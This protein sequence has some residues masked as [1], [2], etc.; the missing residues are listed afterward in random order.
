MADKKDENPP[1]PTVEK[2]PAATEEAA[3]STEDA[4]GQATPPAEPQS[5]GQWFNFGTEWMA[6]AKEQ[7]LNTLESVK[8]SVKKD[9][10]EFQETVSKEAT[11]LASASQ[12]AVKQQAE[13]LQQFVSTP[14]TAESEKPKEK[15]GEASGFGL[16]WMKGL[17]ETVKSLSMEDTTK[18]EAAI[19]EPVKVGTRNS[20]L[21]QFLLLEIQNSEA[22]FLKPPTAHLEVYKE[23]LRDF[24]LTEYNGKFNNQQLLILSIVFA[25][26]IN[27]LLANNPEL[28][29]IF[30]KIVPAQVDNYTFWNRYFF[31]IYVAE[32]EREL[33]LSK[34]KMFEQLNVDTTNGAKLKAEEKRG[35]HALSPA[36]TDNE[37]WSVCSSGTADL[38]ELPDETESVTSDKLAGP[39]TPK[40]GDESPSDE[41][42][43]WDKADS[44]KSS[45]SSSADPQ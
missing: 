4:D 10:N 15:A 19:T 29:K 14:E 1:T 2:Q 3:E 11:A 37:S 27:I 23:W 5:P 39:L 6:K 12:K 22:T 40:A 24:K 26:E 25:G 16:G 42:E 30:S 8:E 31:K 32:M 33:R 45:K 44:S 35:E 20:A 34:G 18:D 21:D 36:A 9:L 41:W 17:V 38:Q 7:T 28:R 13:L 43:K